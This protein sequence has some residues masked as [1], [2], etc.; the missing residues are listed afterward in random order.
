MTNAS[1]AGT[2]ADYYDTYSLRYE[3]ERRAGYF[4]L[5]NDLEFEKIAPDAKGAEALEIGCGTGLILERVAGVAARAVGIDLSPGMVAVSG[6]KGLT[7]VNASVNALPFPDASFDVV[8]SCKVLAHVPDIRGGIAEVARVLR[9][10]GH[11]FLEFYNRRSLRALGYRMRSRM[12]RSE[13]VFVRFDTLA[14]VL[15]YVPRDLSYHSARGI[16]VFGPSGHFYRW[17]V[18]RTIFEWLDR[19]ACDTAFGRRYGGY[20]MVELARAA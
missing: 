17:P 1:D 5:I 18:V 6:E 4:A 2:I 9:P 7:A 19:R 11:A 10:G 14:D 15:T 20:L 16:R 12:D 13:P 8:Y 3:A